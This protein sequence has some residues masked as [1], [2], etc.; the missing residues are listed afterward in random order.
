MFVNGEN[1]VKIN[2]LFILQK[3]KKNV[4]LIFKILS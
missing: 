1:I 2:I 4:D 3:K